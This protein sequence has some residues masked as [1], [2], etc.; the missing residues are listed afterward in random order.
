VV[1]GV[2]PRSTDLAALAHRHL[3]F[4]TF[5]LEPPIV[6]TFDPRAVTARARSRSVCMPASF[7]LPAVP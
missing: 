7:C 4:S 2:L 1:L 6:R 5:S 3:N